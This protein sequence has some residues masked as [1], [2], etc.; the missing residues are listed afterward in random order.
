M[1]P[2]CFTVVRLPISPTSGK[3]L[4]EGSI[5]A[6]FLYPNCKNAKSNAADLLRLLTITD[7]AGKQICA[8]NRRLGF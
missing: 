4:E 7:Q 6:F 8:F 3:S 1:T 5:A 2:S